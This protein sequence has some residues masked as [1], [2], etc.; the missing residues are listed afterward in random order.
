MYSN[1]SEGQTFE[2]KHLQ[3]L[4]VNTDSAGTDFSC[5]NLTSVDVRFWRLK[6][7]DVGFWRL[8]SVDVGLGTGVKIFIMAVDL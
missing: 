5:Q 8:K 4:M 1:G 2:T 3:I 7:V 6:S